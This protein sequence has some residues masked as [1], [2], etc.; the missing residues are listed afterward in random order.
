ML[1]H[2]LPNST[3][4]GTRQ[5]ITVWKESCASPTHLRNAAI[6][7]QAQKALQEEERWS[8]ARLFSLDPCH[9]PGQGSLYAHSEL[10]FFLA[11]A[12]TA[13]RNKQFLNLWP[14]LNADAG[15]IS[16]KTPI[17]SQ[18]DAAYLNCDH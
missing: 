5:L 12:P 6:L 16:A 15:K 3:C 8:G 11:V 18:T 14:C 7:K 13:K 2:C 9:S 1:N 17:P 4:A 10:D